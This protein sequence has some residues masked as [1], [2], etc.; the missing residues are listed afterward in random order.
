M[1]IDRIGDHPISALARLS[2]PHTFDELYSLVEDIDQNGQIRPI[3]RDPETGEIYDGKGRLKACEILGIPPEFAD[4]EE[5]CDP[6]HL[7]LRE[8]VIGRHLNQNDLAIFGH[9]LSAGFPAGWLGANLHPPRMTQEK[10]AER[11]GVSLRLIKHAAKA[12]TTNNDELWQALLR[13]QIKASDASFVVNKP[14]E[15]QQMALEMVLGGQAKTMQS[16]ARKV[17]E[18]LKAEAGASMRETV[19]AHPPSDTIRVVHSDLNGLRKRVEKGSVGVIVT[20]PPTTGVEWGGNFQGLG[21]FAVH[22][23]A[24]DGLTAVMAV[25]QSLPD[26]LFRLTPLGLTWITEFDYRCPDRPLRLK[27]PYRGQVGRLPILVFGKDKTR[28]PAGDDFVEEPPEGGSGAFK[29]DQLSDAGLQMVVE[30]F[31]AP[32]QVV[33]DPVILGRIGT[34]LGARN[35]GC[36]FIG[37]AHDQNLINQFWTDMAKTMGDEPA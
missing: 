36:T 5:G 25:P 33:C 26:V 9:F 12:F 17:E 18:H 34:A 31:A 4:L 3:V 13:R 32:G 37:A 1:S 6:W 23:L 21:K 20:F 16:A 35:A 30:R 2:P 28:V 22:A 19:L 15:V 14:P 11:L 24:P 8:N 10:T 29:P 7:I 27:Y